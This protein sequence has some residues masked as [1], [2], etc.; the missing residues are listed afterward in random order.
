MW[1]CCGGV[2]FVLCVCVYACVYVC[3]CLRVCMYVCLCVWLAFQPLSA[4]L[5]GQSMFC[6]NYVCINFGIC[7]RPQVSELLTVCFAEHSHFV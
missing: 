7:S 2:Y 6:A 4:S 1:V 5:C 3:V